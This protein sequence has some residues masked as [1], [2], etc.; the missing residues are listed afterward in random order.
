MM[1]STILRI[2]SVFYL[3]YAMASFSGKIGAVHVSMYNVHAHR[4]KNIK[5]YDHNIAQPN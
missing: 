4:V 5:E 2:F 1:N 3:L